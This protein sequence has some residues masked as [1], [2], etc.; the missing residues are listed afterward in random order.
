M[1]INSR[2]DCMSKKKIGIIV[3]VIVAVLILG[4]VGI[5]FLV[6]APTA[7]DSE[8]RV[9][10]EQVSSIMSVNAGTESRFNGVVESQDTYEVN[11]DSSR[12][13]EKIHVK[14]GD[15]VEAGQKIVTYDTSDIQLQI[16]QANLEV[17]SIN[18][19]IANYTAQIINQNTFYQSAEEAEKQYI[20]SEIQNL[21]NSISQKQFDLESK[22]LEIAKYKE[23]IKKSTVSTEVGG[24]VK[25]INEQGIDANGNSAP[26]MTILQ[27]GEYR[28][29]GSIDEQNIWTLSEG[30]PVILRSRVDETKTWAGTIEKIDTDNPQQNNNNYYG[31][32]EVV[33]ASKYP[34]YVV[35]EDATGLILGQHLY[36]EL[37]Q[38]QEEEKEGIWLSSSYIVQE[39]DKAYVWA[40]N[41]RNRLEKRTVELGEYD[42]TMDQYQILSG[43]TEEDY[44]C[45]PM[46]GLYEGVVTVTNIEEQ[47]WN[48]EVE[49][50]ATM[51][52]MMMEDGM[53]DEYYDMGTEVLE[54]TY[55]MDMST[56][57]VEEME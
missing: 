33:M 36:I 51:D 41:S 15:V 52:D 45:W 20:L 13:I 8:N 18:N 16:D 19:E 4:G 26:F 24:T 56:E 12:T 42:E 48:P 22:E 32:G 21:Q 2:R 55:E 28:V 23:Q 5:Y 1:M 31:E 27:S 11:V 30:M 3:G 9:Y 49:D 57:F 35:L 39:E 40:S 34:F 38:G 29:K 6:G 47:V 50:G 17:E 7:G 44:I 10:V 54:E 46:E 43:L 53:M 14:V 25:E 37:N